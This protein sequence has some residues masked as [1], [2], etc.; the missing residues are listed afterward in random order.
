MCLMRV[1]LSY[2]SEN[3]ARAEEIALA[4]KAMGHRVFLDADQLKGGEDYNQVIREQLAQADR[5]LFLISPHAVEP[6]AYTLTELRAAQER[7]PHPRH[8]V[9]PVLLQPTEMDSI[10]TYLKAVTIF[11]PAGNVAAEIAGHIGPARRWNRPLIWAAGGILLVGAG[12]AAMRLIPGV[13]TW[14]PGVKEAPAGSR[15]V[16]RI[17]E[18]D[19]VTQ[20]VLNVERTEYRL[21]PTAR[22]PTDRGDV[23]DVNRVAF[24]KLA[25]GT[26]AFSVRIGVT[27]TNQQPIL[28]D[29]TPR[30]FELLDN[31][32]QKAELQFF[33]CEAK[34]EMLGPAQQ[35]EIQLI[36]R[37]RGGWQGKETSAS[38]IHFH[39]SGLLPLARGTWTFRPLAT[40]N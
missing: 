17:A 11:Q 18:S 14:G 8:H 27:N 4:L 33:C 31:R 39:V 36:Y 28:L 23:V 24:G 22:F 21:D 26:P 2:A 38:L 30:F 34:G 25:D 9:L 3:R 5:F 29:L 16:S 12:V 15:F 35:R 1:F 7:W 20:F 13:A 19:F 10:P 40:A 6:G 32:G 37:S